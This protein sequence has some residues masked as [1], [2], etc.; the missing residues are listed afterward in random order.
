ME[1]EKQ[2]ELIKEVAKE[3]GYQIDG[4]ETVFEIYTDQWHSVA[5]Q[6]KENSAGYLQVHQWE[7]D[8]DDGQY[9]RAIYS[10][11]TLSDVIRFCHILISSL[12]LRAKR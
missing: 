7:E 11:R 8:D 12:N 10:L 9:G 1:N 3:H 4:G 6:I 2:K 5:F